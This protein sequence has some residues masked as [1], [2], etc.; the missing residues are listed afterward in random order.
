LRLPFVSMSGVGENA[1]KALYNAAQSSDFI[2]V[3]EFSLS[4]GVSKT[5]IEQ[6]K[7]FGAFGDMPDSA[8]MSLF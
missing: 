4:A 5:V 8:Q 1:A 6:L 3:E 2:S 7:S